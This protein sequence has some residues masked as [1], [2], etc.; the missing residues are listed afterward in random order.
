MQPVPPGT[1]ENSP[2]IHRWDNR[3]Q[4]HPSLGG[5]AEA[6]E[7]AGPQTQRMPLTPYTRSFVPDGTCSHLALKTQSDES[8]GW[9]GPVSGSCPARPA[10]PPPPRT[11][12]AR[13]SPPAASSP[14]AASIPP[15]GSGPGRCRADRG[16]PASTG[17]RPRAANAL[18]SAGI[19]RKVAVEHRLATGRFRLWRAVSIVGP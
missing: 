19:T 14:S 1:P 10:A 18:Q 9:G 7:M 13:N 15:G 6:R 5:A 17:D 3:S 4:A 16:F 12:R 2:A 8:L 11:P